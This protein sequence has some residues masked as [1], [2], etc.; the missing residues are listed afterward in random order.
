MKIY[1]V[2]LDDYDMHDSI[3][4]FTELS[5]A[6]KCRD[7][8]NRTRPSPYEDFEWEVVEYNRDNIDYDTKIKELD[9]KDKLRKIQQQ[10]KIKQKELAELARL[11]AKYGVK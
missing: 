7:Y 8:L 2:K 3:G 9:E 1:I 4:Y 6:E 11:K 5:K 10:E